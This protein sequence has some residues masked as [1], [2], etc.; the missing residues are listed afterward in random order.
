MGTLAVMIA[1]GFVAL[2]WVY[3]F[4]QL[5]LLSDSDFP[6]RHDKILWV[7]AFVLAFL[8]APFA[9][10]WWKTGYRMVRREEQS[11]DLESS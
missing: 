4:V 2:L 5:M 7:A 6:G 3:Q 8:V 11:A 10:L 1:A 9:F